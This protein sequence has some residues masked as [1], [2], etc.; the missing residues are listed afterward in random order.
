MV[1]REWRLSEIK[2]PVEGMIGTRRSGSR[3]GCNESARKD[4]CHFV[5]WRR[6]SFIWG[7]MSHQKASFRMVSIPCIHADNLPVLPRLSQDRWLRPRRIIH[8]PAL[9]AITTYIRYPGSAKNGQKSRTP[10][11]NLKKAAR[12][13]WYGLPFWVAET[14]RPKDSTVSVSLSDSIW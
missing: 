8:L 5:R 11:W 3:V 9:N 4:R 6:R 13:Q 12:W 1:E 7:E 10:S 14:T 2:H